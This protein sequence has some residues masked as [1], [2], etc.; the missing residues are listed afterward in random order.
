ML[1]SAKECAVEVLDEGKSC[2]LTSGDGDPLLTEQDGE[3][4][5][6]L[7]H[8]LAAL[9]SAWARAGRGQNPKL[10]GWQNWCNWVQLL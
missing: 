1:R 8:A 9:V 4:T 5:Q 6:A 2:A 7:S 10:G 3:L